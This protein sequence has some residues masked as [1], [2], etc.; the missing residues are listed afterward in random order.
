M[1]LPN[2]PT[3]NLYKF[4]AISGLAIFLFGLYL[5]NST[6]S[7]L[8]LEIN[9]LK[10]EQEILQLS[11]DDFNKK[12]LDSLEFNHQAQIL[13][14][15]VDQLPKTYKGYLTLTFLGFLIS[16][17]GFFQWYHKLQI[18]Q[19]KIV[20]NEGEK[21][22]NQ[23]SVITHQIR[24]EQELDL[25]KR[26]WEPLSEFKRGLNS[27]MSS[28]DDYKKCKKVDRNDQLDFVNRNFKIAHGHFSELFIITEK[29]H[30]SGVVNDFSSFRSHISL[31]KM[32]SPV[33]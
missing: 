20:K 19:N 18:H 28:I 26:T 1:N 14:K 16:I 9:R 24:F 30:R 12:S 22:E 33:L 6:Q 10:L 2:I 25:Y 15:K 31:E 29:N 5:F 17:F 4:I 23:K 8:L 32:V 3:D 21:A 27:L 13:Q 11:N 7:E